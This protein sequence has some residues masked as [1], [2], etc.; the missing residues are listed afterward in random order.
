MPFQKGFLYRMALKGLVARFHTGYFTA[1]GGVLT[2][3]RKII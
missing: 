1:G 3:Y 2:V